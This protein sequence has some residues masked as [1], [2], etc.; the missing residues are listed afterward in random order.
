MLSK[1]VFWC[2]KSTE[3]FKANISPL[4][5]QNKKCYS[6]PHKEEGNFKDLHVAP[7]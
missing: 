7:L 3:C 5:G 2:F 1:T 6:Y 4:A